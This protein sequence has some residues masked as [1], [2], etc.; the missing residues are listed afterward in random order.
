M[1]K[2]GNVTQQLKKKKI[3]TAIGRAMQSCKTLDV[4]VDD[5]FREVTKMVTSAKG[6]QREVQNFMFVGKTPFG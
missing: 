2:G 3:T 4:N 1:G 6:A 5:L